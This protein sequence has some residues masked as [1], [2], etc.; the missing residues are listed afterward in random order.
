VPAHQAHG[1]N[2]VL[3]QGFQD[4]ARHALGLQAVAEYRQR[5]P[6]TLC[7]AH[8]LRAL[9]RSP[10]TVFWYGSAAIYERAIRYCWEKSA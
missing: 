3:T 1:A 10:M 6:E 2:S 4:D 8:H 9:R 7:I 5:F